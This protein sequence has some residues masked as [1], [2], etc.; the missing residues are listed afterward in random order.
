MAVST[1]VADREGEER[2]CFCC[3]GDGQVVNK[4]RSAPDKIVRIT[5]L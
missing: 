2:A 4:Q 5:M 1:T 3:A